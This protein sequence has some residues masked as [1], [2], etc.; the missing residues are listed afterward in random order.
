MSYGINLIKA[1]YILLLGTYTVKTA[2]LSKAIEEQAIGRVVRL[3]QTKQVQVKRFII[4]DTI[5][6]ER[7]NYSNLN[8]FLN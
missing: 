1:N 2:C 3:G 7:F 8:F 5:E 4:D 6:H